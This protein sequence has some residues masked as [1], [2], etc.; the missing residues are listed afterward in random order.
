MEGVLVLDTNVIFSGLRSKLGA[1]FKLLSLI[2]KNKFEIAIS[3]AL[4]L[5]YEDVLKRN[6]G[7]GIK[8]TMKDISEFLDY[9]CK[10]GVKTE[11]FY[12][13]RPFLKDSSDDMV[14]ELAVA[15][16]AKFIVTYNLNDFEGVEQFGVKA[17]T[18]KEYLI[19]IGEI[20]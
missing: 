4:I 8:L 9:V 19:M 3:P 13:W 14:L 10:I 2:P 12:I 11:I 17:I 5:E 7:K 20:E 16:N 15:S 18:P 6:A 1:S